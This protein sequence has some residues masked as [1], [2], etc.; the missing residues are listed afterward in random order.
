M[1]TLTCRICGKQFESN[2]PNRSYCKGPHYFSCPVCSKKFCVDKNK[3]YYEGK[4]GKACCCK[5]CA[6][7]FV[8]SN[9]S[10]QQKQHR[11]QARIATMQEKYGVVNPGQMQSVLEKRKQTN[12]KKFG[13]EYANQSEQIKQKTR[14]TNLK[15]YGVEYT[16]Q[17]KP[18]K[19]KIKKTLVE[20]YGADHISKT[21]HFK[22]KLKETSREK[23]GIDYPIASKQVRDKIHA[24]TLKHYGVEN[25]FYSSEL[26][27]KAVKTKREKY[28]HLGP[29]KEQLREAYQKHYGV[30][31]Y[32]QTQEYADKVRQT[33]LEK[34]GL[35]HFQ[36][37]ESVKQARVDTCMKKYGV[38][39]VRKAEQVKQHIRDVFMEKYGYDCA[40]KVPEIRRKQVAN[41]RNSKLEIR[42]AN[43]L[44]EYGIDYV[45]QFVV[46]KGNHVH[47]FDFYIPEYKI[48]LDADGKYYHS[49][50]CDPDGKQVRDDYDEVRMYLVP[51]DHTFILAV[52]GEEDKAVKHVYD[53]IKSM[54]ANVFD[55]DTELF[56]WCRS[57]EFPYPQYSDKRMQHDW[58]SLCSYKNSKYI[59]QCKLGMS[60]VKN[61]HPSIYDARVGSSVSTKEAWHDDAKLKKV[62]ANRLIY[63][64]AVDPNK[65]LQ[66]FNISKIGPTVS[67]F[68]PVL[69]RYLTLKYLSEYT[70]V[71]DPFSGFSGR[72]LGV[73]STGKQYAGQDISS[74]HVQES[75]SIVQ[76]L[77]LQSCCNVCC[78]DVLQSSASYECLL[79]CP[80]YS[81]KET[82]G[83]ETQFKSCDEWI[84]EC[85]QRFTCKAYVFVV[86]CTE[87]YKQYV[88]ETLHNSS[89]F[90]KAKE[91]VVV[92]K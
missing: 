66:G 33:S 1:Y 78:K 15:K 12:L 14:E 76:F 68:N 21:E 90:S 48:L 59:P 80:P 17:A 28:G 26:Q 24:T 22:E 54:D 29:T 51:N 38:D 52:E 43:L 46:S 9:L 86:D 89:H 82:Y 62:I 16:F 69:A 6:R 91:H 84:D 81:R 44:S 55:Y 40:S 61:F 50:L 45:T 27:A 11:K 10:D 25:P 41:A 83:S 36:S 20:K 47:A 37:A 39:N 56:K 30:D 88:T 87:K 7:A 18:V 13:T 23:Y 60:M 77:S 2:H 19:E 4:E 67:L 42:V 32:T 92:I 74:A 8:E 73:A 3:A 34:Y 57:I 70:Q 71:F 79:T 72:L 65:V 58:Q 64:N 5:V 49:Y 35:E 85:L 63:Q 31:F 75:R 53:V